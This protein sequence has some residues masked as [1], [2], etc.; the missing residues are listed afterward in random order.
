[1][2]SFMLLSNTPLNSIEY[3]FSVTVSCGKIG[4]SIHCN[5][6]QVKKGANTLQYKRYLIPQV[7]FVVDQS[8][9]NLK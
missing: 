2:L 3:A 8:K 7:V 5:M 9:L 6:L 4:A 1:M